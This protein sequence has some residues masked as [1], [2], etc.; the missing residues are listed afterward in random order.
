[1]SE[2]NEYV[3]FL[4]TA[5]ERERWWF[6]GIAA[7]AWKMQCGSDTKLGVREWIVAERERER[8][9]IICRDGRGMQQYR[10]QQR[11]REREITRVCMDGTAAASV[12]ARER[13]RQRESN[14]CVCMYGF[15]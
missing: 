4:T 1:V 6:G 15:V 8:E 13:E 12:C 9:R 10:E 7:T 14:K 2:R 5:R 3:C 11:E